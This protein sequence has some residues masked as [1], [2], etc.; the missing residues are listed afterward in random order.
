[1]PYGESSNPR[2]NIVKSR[3]GDTEYPKKAALQRIE[4]KY[5]NTNK[6]GVK[7]DQRLGI[8]SQPISKQ[9]RTEKTEIGKYPSQ[10]GKANIGGTLENQESQ[11]ERMT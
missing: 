9:N 1:M 10:S 11:I 4:Q 6:K 7:Q 8:G 5:S 2:L 3:L